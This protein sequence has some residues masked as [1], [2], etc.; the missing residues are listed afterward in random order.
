MLVFTLPIVMMRYA[1]QQYV[2]RT[3]DSVANSSD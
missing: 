2:A 3:E 1:R